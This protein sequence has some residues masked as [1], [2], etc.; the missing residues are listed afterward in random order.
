MF[1]LAYAAVPLYKIFCQ[2]TGFGGTTQVSE[3]YYHAKKGTK[4]I[5]VSFDANVQPNLKW[6]FQ[7][8]Q[9]SVE[10]KTGENALIFYNAKNISDK[11]IIGTAIYN[12]TPDA[13][14]QYFNKIQCFC[15][16]E[17]LLKKGQAM[18]MPVSFY[19]DPEFENDPDLKDVSQITLSYS[20]FKVKEVN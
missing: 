10:V 17:Q 15:F 2:V 16:E 13:A 20:F 18:Q 5:K 7:P 4:T 9:R 11:N 1:V 14:G 6:S 19:I 3:T 8:N 12:V